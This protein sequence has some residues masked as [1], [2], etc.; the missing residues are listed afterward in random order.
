MAGV[1]V[2]AILLCFHLVFC[3]MFG[4]L[5]IDIFLFAC[6]LT[7]VACISQHAAPHSWTWTIILF[8]SLLTLHR[9]LL[10]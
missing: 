7:T 8:T 5:V 6:A 1:P 9:P 10:L 2:I 3:I 4:H